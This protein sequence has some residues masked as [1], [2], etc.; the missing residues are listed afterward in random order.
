M[1]RLRYDLCAFAQA[2]H[3]SRG[4]KR[5][6]SAIGTVIRVPRLR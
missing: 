6:N 2:R 4:R 5:P 3:R 1:R